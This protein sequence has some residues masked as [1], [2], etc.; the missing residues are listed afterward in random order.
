[1]KTKLWLMSLTTL[2]INAC[3]SSDSNTPVVVPDP[4]PPPAESESKK[5]AR[6]GDYFLSVTNWQLTHL[7][8]PDESIVV[9]SVSWCTF[10]GIDNDNCHLHAITKVTQRETSYISKLSVSSPK[11]TPAVELANKKY[12]SVYSTDESLDGNENY[13]ILAAEMD[14]VYKK[15]PPGSVLTIEQ[16]FDLKSS[17]MQ[18]AMKHY[19]DNYRCTSSPIRALFANSCPIDEGNILLANYSKDISTAIYSALKISIE[20]EPKSGKVVGVPLHISNSILGSDD[21]AEI[22]Y[23]DNPETLLTIPDAGSATLPG[24]RSIVFL[25]K[26]LSKAKQQRAFT[27]MCDHLYQKAGGT[28]PEYIGDLYN[29]A[30]STSTDEKASAL[31]EKE[32]RF[33]YK[34]NK[35]M[36]LE[37]FFSVAENRNKEIYSLSNSSVPFFNSEV[38]NFPMTIEQFLIEKPFKGAACESYLN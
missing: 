2:L 17:Q 24:A 11:T 22:P 1:M 15:T 20:F 16:S 18:Q 12:Y 25:G 13:E 23:T 35:N 4:G 28:G 38:V 19:Y 9:N 10:D 32:Y 31:L 27:E 34:I 33:S 36:S 14:S 37:D 21:H 6:K 29:P 7:N 26:N 30:F 5:S 3:S 8:N